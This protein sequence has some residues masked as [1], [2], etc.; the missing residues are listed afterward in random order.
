MRL[1]EATVKG[2]PERPAIVFIHGLGMDK[3]IWTSPDDAKILGNRFP[4]HLI[5]PKEPE[6]EVCVPHCRHPEHRGL[7]LG[8][9]AGPLK[10]LFHDLKEEGFTV[11]A[12]SQQR[13]SAEIDIAVS[14]LRGVVISAKSYTKAG[15]IL[16]G[17]SRGG[18]VARKYLE[19]G[20]KGIRALVT[21]STPNHGSRMAQ[22]A[23]YLS[24]LT[25]V[26]SP[27]MPD[28]EKGTLTYT[29]KKVV[30][31]LKSKAVKELLPDSD[32]FKNFNDKKPEGAYCVSAGGTDPALLC[33]YRWKEQR[34]NEGRV[35]LNPQKILSI[36]DVFENIMPRSLLPDEMKNG[37]GDGL[38]SARSSRLPLADAH[39][40]FGVNH[41]GILFDERV[42]AK[43][44]YSLKKII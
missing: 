23:D 32:F 26:L 31:F 37:Y 40:D 22:W 43:I 39:Y 15:I 41:A 16:I 4:I 42:R 28:S 18:L 29:F 14:E 38:V 7:F 19:Q 8:R 1:D 11:I 35:L 44:V 5:A 6:A 13:P 30:D 9:A 20:A 27:L 25:S 24:P 10:T 2:D 21:L 33:L 34:V 17:H 36:P 3:R 12:W